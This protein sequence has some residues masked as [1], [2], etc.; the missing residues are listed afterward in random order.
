MCIYI[1]INNYSRN[2]NVILC[3]MDA[4]NRNSIIGIQQKTREHTH[5]KERNCVG[6][7]PMSAVLQRKEIEMNIFGGG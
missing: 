4:E 6:R 5:T 1:I 7:G 3:Q 2:D